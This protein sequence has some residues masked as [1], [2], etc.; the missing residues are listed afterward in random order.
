VTC[1]YC[2]AVWLTKRRM[3]ICHPSVPVI[4]SLCSFAAV[5]VLGASPVQEMARQYCVSCHD[6]DT[7]KGDLDLES[8][9]KDDP[10]THAGT[11]EKAVRLLNARQMP[12]LGKKRPPDTEYEDA[13]AALTAELDRNAAAHPAPGRTDTLRRL[14]RTEYQ[15]AIRDL[16]AVEIDASA[17]L[18]PDEASHGFDNV[19]VG[20]L[21]P[22]LLERYIATAQRVS[23]MAVGRVAREPEVETI[24]IRPDITQEERVEGLPFGTRGG[25]L[26]KHTFPQDGAYEVQVRLM[27]DR[28]EVVEGLNG[29]HQLEVLRDRE[30]L[31]SFTLKPPADRKDY[32]KVDANLKTRFEVKA[33]LHDLGVTFIDKGAP[34]LERLRQPYK[35]SFNFHRHPRLSPAVFQVSITGPFDA[36]GPGDTP[37]RKR[38]FVAYPKSAAEDETCAHEVIAKVLRRAYRRPVGHEDIERIVAV[39]RNARAADGMDF[40][41]GIEAALSAVLVSREFLFRTERDPQGIPPKTPYPVTGL[42]L[43]SRLSFFLWSSIPDDALLNAAQRGE[44]GQTETLEREARRMLADPRSQSLVTNFAEQWLYLR[45]LDSFTPDGRR[46]PDFDDNLRQAFRE[47]TAKL[48]SSILRQDCSVLELLRTDRTW[49]NERLAQHYGIPH[50]YGSRFREVQLTPN[51]PRGGL[52]R[53]ASILAVTSYATRTSPVLRGHWILK[54]VLGAPPPPPPPNVPALEENTVSVSLPMRQRLA[55]HR[56]NAACASCHNLMDPVGFALENYDAVGRWRLAE[57]GHAVD[58]TG[59][60]PDGSTFAG[61]SGLEEALLKRPELFVA[62]LTEKLLTYALGRGIGPSDAPA[63]R[64]VVRRAAKKDFRLSEIVVSVVTSTPFTMRSTP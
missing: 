33:G 8:I 57:D 48:F 13:V 5:T 61:A 16:L 31:A 51:M 25:T 26:L 63:V 50:I 29:E 34:L 39:Y 23:R 6:A 38:L 4:A 32:T 64:E 17:L 11:W 41:G 40:D 24:R 45:N 9:L 7:R 3:S 52:L 20:D 2:I 42:E 53:Q 21:P 14:T 55:V 44:L 49:L 46:F 54:N 30:R 12:P 59:S 56:D 15:H 18:P 27:R 10:A 60:L 62:T 58:A 37:S 28:N 22:V 43:A 19:T 1:A 47:E 36:K 35:A